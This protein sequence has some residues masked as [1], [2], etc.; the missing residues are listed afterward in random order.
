VPPKLSWGVPLDMFRLR[1]IHFA[2]RIRDRIAYGDSLV[3]KKKL[4]FFVRV[5]DR[6]LLDLLGFY[7]QDIAA[8]RSLGFDVQVETSLLKAF[9]ARADA[10]Y[11]WWWH[12]SMPLVLV[13]R[14]K[15]RPVVVTGATDLHNDVGLSAIKRYI[16]LV[17]TFVSAHAASWNIAISEFEGADFKRLHVRRWSVIHLSTATIRTP[18]ELSPHPSAV[19]IAQMNPLSIRRKGVDIAIEAGREV[20][21]TCPEFV[22]H[23]VGPISAE[24][25][26]MLDVMVRGEGWIRVHGEVTEEKKHELLARAWF[27]LQPSRYEGFGL[28][29]AEGMSAGCIPVVSAAGSL[30]E[31]VGA[32]GVV[33]GGGPTQIAAALL[34]LIQDD[35]RRERLRTGTAMEA[36]RFQEDRK[37][38]DLRLVMRAAGCQPF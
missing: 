37:I 34:R 20:F 24:G 32:G 14:F 8:L 21:V 1:R 23:L 33:E 3:E 9:V 10:Y 27:Y 11:C 18:A 35:A 26:E 22:L 17:L 2:G 28:A 19:L 31:V 12:T 5:R 25:Q 7:S 16:R 30:P 36:R 38:D 4:V 13:A 6:R 15:R 29:V